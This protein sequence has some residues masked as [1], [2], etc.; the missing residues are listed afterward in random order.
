[1]SLLTNLVNYYKLDESSGNAVDTVGGLTL[2]NTN[3]TYTTGK[4]NN[5]AVFNASANL[6]SSSNIGI[7][8]ASARSLNFWHKHSGATNDGLIAWGAAVQGQAF[9]ILIG[10]NFAFAGF[11]DDKDFGVAINDGNWHMGTVTFDGTTIICYTDGANKT[12]FT[13]SPALN[14]TNSTLHF[15][16]RFDGSQKSTGSLD[17]VGIWTRVLND[18]EVAQL[19]N[20]GLGKPYSSFNSAGFLGLL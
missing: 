5:G 19:Y 14:T 11:S 1:M 18:G 10:T 3:T 12:T 8:G 4:I 20:S 9:M 15:G 13:P 2:T 6:V 16:E 7:S 17:E